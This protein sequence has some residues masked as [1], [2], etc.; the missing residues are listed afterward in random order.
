MLGILRATSEQLC[1]VF[2][3]LYEL[4]MVFGFLRLTCFMTGSMEASIVLSDKYVIIGAVRSPGL[5]SLG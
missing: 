5:T 2:V 1:F 3:V 4:A